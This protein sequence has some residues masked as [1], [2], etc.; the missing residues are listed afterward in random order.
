MINASGGAIVRAGGRNPRSEARGIEVG[1]SRAARPIMRVRMFCYGETCGPSL[2][3]EAGRGLAD[4]RAG[5][6][7]VGTLRRRIG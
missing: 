2:V 6:L 4:V 1:G 3:R 7:R 5:M